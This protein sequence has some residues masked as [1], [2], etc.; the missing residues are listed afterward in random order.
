MSSP[1]YIVADSVI[2]PLGNTSAAC[3][4]AVERGESG[5]TLVEDTHLSP[6]PFYAARIDDSTLPELSEAHTR[7]ERLCILSVNDALCHTSIRLDNKDTIFILS[8]T[9]G[10]IELLAEGAPDNE[11]SLTRSADRIAAHFGAV[12]KP[13]V[14]S[15]ACISGVLAIITAKR[16]INSG[17]YKH[18]VVTGADVLSKFVVS[19]FQSLMAMSDEPCRPFDKGRKGINLGEG[20]ATVVLTNDISQVQQDSIQV[21]GEGLTNDA[22]H[23]SG[24]SRTGAELADA[25]IKAL[26]R[27]R[28][29]AADIS[30]VSAHGT[31]TLYNDEMESKAFE[32]AGLSETP[33]HSLKGYF[34]HTLG[35]AGVIETVMTIHSLREHKILSSLHYHENGVS[36]SITVNTSMLSSDRNH[37][38]KTASGFGGCNAA[39]VY[40][41]PTGTE[42]TKK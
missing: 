22:N 17:R 7:F 38:L 39:I 18:A 9:K 26:Q 30:F 14:V 19:G 2:S 12:H 13:I 32:L 16:L 24:P 27:S 23:I 35:A 31:A 10:N 36:G 42:H 37:A 20:A 5:I 1:V 8:T 6:Q 15:N 40:K 33:L 4:T 11:L 25:V 41:I 34:G 29:S 28:V 21:L 3:Y